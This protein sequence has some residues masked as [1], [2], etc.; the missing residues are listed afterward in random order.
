[1]AEAHHGAQAVLR[2]AQAA[3]ATA[4]AEKAKAQAG[5]SASPMPAAPA[6]SPATSTPPSPPPPPQPVDGALAAAAEAAGK[7]AA[8]AEEV[9]RGKELRLAHITHPHQ[10]WKWLEGGLLPQARLVGA[11]RECSTVT[12]NQRKCAPAP[13][14][15]TDATS[16]QQ[17]G[18]SA[19]VLARLQVRQHR[20]PR[21]RHVLPAAFSQNVYDRCLFS[22]LGAGHVCLNVPPD[23]NTGLW[24][25]PAYGHDT[26]LA[27]LR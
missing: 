27:D 26:T 2:A 10:F 13:P 21:R 9:R 14:P 15:G 4:Q 25:T 1:M 19:V 17:D 23:C 16:F 22:K 18:V 11:P 20:Q 3:A 8:A 7:A 5:A 24:E 12:A 6:A